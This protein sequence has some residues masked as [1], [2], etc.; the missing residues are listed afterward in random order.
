MEAEVFPGSP[1][2]LA[3]YAAIARVLV[4]QGDRDPPEHP[5]VLR[6][7]SEP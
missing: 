6:G 5:R 7:R 4:E 3:D 1:A 2:L